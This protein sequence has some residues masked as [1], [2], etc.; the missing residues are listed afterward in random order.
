[1][2][3]DVRT[4]SIDQLRA[5]PNRQ[6]DPPVHLIFFGL[7][8][9]AENGLARSFDVLHGTSGPCPALAPDR[10]FDDMRSKRCAG[11][12]W[13]NTARSVR[14]APAS[15]A[16]A[17]R[18]PAS[19][20]GRQGA[21]AAASG[22]PP[23]ALR[24]LRRRNLG[25][26]AQSSFSISTSGFSPRRWCALHRACSTPSG[27]VELPTVMYD[28]AGDIGQQAVGSA[29]TRIEGEQHGRGDMQPFRPCR[30][31]GNRFPPDA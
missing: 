26:F 29:E 1:V 3:L 11:G 12:G 22:V 20:R 2:H 13:Y 4:R 24:R 6:P 10:R 18:V 28:N 25:S 16:L 30:Q 19:S 27:V 8:S 9:Q 14:S 15:M 23:L 31:C 21:K 5:K 17:A 7:H